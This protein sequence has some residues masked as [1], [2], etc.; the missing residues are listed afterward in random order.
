MSGPAYVQSTQTSGSGSPGTLAYTSNNTAGNL[1]I[2]MP[3]GGGQV[4]ESITD[5]QGNSWS[6]AV[7]GI[8]NP[9]SIR[10]QALFYAFNCKSGANTITLTMGNFDFWNLFIAEYSGVQSSSDPLDK[11]ANANG[12]SASMNSG[13]ITTTGSNDLIIDVM[14]AQQNSVALTDGSTVRETASFSSWVLSDQDQSGAGT[15]AAT[16]TC[17]SGLWIAQIV[18][19]LASSGGGAVVTPPNTNLLVVPTFRPRMH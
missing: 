8:I 18:S 1:L 3:F 10:T 12:N 9:G 13:N 16:A 17:N 7:G 2:A 4:S 11:N 15:T 19:F 5:S 6:S 14:Q